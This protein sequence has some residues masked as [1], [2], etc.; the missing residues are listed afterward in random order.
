MNKLGKFHYV[1]CINCVL[2][3]MPVTTKKKKKMP[4]CFTEKKGVT[5][6]K[7]SLI[8][9]TTLI[10]YK[11]FISF[12]FVTFSD[13]NFGTY[14][15]QLLCGSYCGQPFD[16]SRF[17]TFPDGI[18]NSSVLIRFTIHLLCYLEYTTH[19]CG[20]EKTNLSKIECL[21]SGI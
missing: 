13:F 4:V 21:A 3:Q 8:S 12:S 1:K 18:H 10:F 19:Q 6:L 14:S 11:T 15:V 16:Q 20:R 2:N 9:S 7:M 5:N 17:T